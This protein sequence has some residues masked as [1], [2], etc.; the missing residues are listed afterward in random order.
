[1]IA[2]DSTG[3]I[4]KIRSLYYVDNVEYYKWLRSHDG[5]NLHR[6]IENLRKMCDV[7]CLIS[8]ELLLHV[9]EWEYGDGKIHGS[10]LEYINRLEISISTGL[11]TFLAGAGSFGYH[12]IKVE[13]EL[14]NIEKV[15]FDACKNK[16]HNSLDVY[17][18]YLIAFLN[19]FR[20]FVIHRSLFDT[21][22]LHFATER[23]PS[24]KIMLM[25]N[26]LLD[27]YDEWN[28]AAKCYINESDGVRVADFVEQYIRIATKTYAAISEYCF[29]NVE[30]YMKYATIM[31]YQH[32]I[33]SEMLKAFPDVNL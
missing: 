12:R 18:K 32:D 20:D 5:Y 28:E 11:F 10:Y 15:H 22:E 33:E 25:K 27:G 9:N 26:E 17:D 23:R 31:R 7:V 19:K 29:K 1:M 14:E 8:N 24:K 6:K 3:V 13:A 30:C 4:E 21:F 16:L 2:D